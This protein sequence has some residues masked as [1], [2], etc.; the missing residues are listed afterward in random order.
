MSPER[1][2]VLRTEGPDTLPIEK[3]RFGRPL[4]DWAE[5]ITFTQ[6]SETGGS[7]KD[8]PLIT[9]SSQRACPGNM[10]RSRK[11]TARRSES[12]ENCHDV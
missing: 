7:L 10:E 4:S 2:Q 11:P 12:A 1:F 5:D 3:D 6:T 8:A 9:A